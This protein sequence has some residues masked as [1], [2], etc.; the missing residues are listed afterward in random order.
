MVRILGKK[1]VVGNPLLYGTR[2]QFLVHF[3]L[4]ALED[5]PSI[6]EFEEF[7][8]ALESEQGQ[9]FRGESGETDEL[10]VTAACTR[11]TRA[12]QTNKDTR[13]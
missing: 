12:E 3:G 10:E 4:N 6:E 2:K 5:L 7:V 9:L 8:G 13:Q 1:K 11:K